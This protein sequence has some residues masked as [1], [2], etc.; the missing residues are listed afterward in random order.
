[1]SILIQN[2]QEYDF[3]VH[4]YKNENA[5]YQILHDQFIKNDMVKFIESLI[6]KFNKNDLENIFAMKLYNYI[7]MN[8]MYPEDKKLLKKGDDTLSVV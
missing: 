2:L 7:K 3:V 4:Y 1:M 8:E 5:Y 6:K